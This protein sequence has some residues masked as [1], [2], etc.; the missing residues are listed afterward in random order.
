MK[1]CSN[2]EKLTVN[3]RKMTK[4]ERINLSIDQQATV[5]EVKKKKR[6]RTWEP[7]DG[8]KQAKDSSQS[9]HNLPLD[10]TVSQ[11]HKTVP[12]KLNQKS[13]KS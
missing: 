12:E 13:R 1:S 3:N 5:G 9:P 8:K 10:V 2:Q 11:K 7:T 4:S 6:R